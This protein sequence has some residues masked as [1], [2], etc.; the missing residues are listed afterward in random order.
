M[1][2]MQEIPNR[3]PPSDLKETRHI[4]TA[5][6]A[7]TSDLSAIRTNRRVHT[8]RRSPATWILVLAMVSSIVV[9]YIWNKLSVDRLSNEI[10]RMERE[11]AQT[12]NTNEILRADINKKSRLDRIGKI[13]TEQLE[14]IY[15]KEQPVWFQVPYLLPEMSQENR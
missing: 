7:P 13:A 12:S 8:H 15:P 14:L 10:S 4:Y 2:K 6:T 9:F 1:A 11:L 5:E 3:L